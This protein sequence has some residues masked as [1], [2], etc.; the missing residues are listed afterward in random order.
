MKKIDLHIHTNST[1]SDYPFEFDFSKLKQYVETLDIACIAIT[2]HNTFDLK[3]Y[4]KIKDD[5]DIVVFPGIEIDLE[6]GHLLV[7]SDNSD[8]S[9][10]NDFSKKCDRVSQLIKTK[11]DDITVEQFADIFPSLDKFLLIPH[12]HK[13]PIVKTETIRKI[14]TLISAGEVSSYKKFK[15]CVK[16]PDSLVP[17]IFSDSR[18]FSEMENFSTQQTWVDL[19]EIS[20]AGIKLCLTDKQK[21]FLTK[22]EGN[23]FFQATAEGLMLSTGLNVILGERSTGKTVTLDKINQ[24]HENIKFIRQFSLL[25]NDEQKFEELLS[26]RHSTVSEDYLKDFKIVVDSV[27]N[28]DLKQNEIDLEKYLNSLLKFASDSE[29]ADAF[30]NTKLFSEN[31]FGKK[32]LSGLRQLI[33]AA[34]TIKENTEYK[35]LINRHITPATLED[36]EIDLMK[37]YLRLEEVNLKRE[38]VNNLITKIKDELIFRTSSPVPSDVDFYRILVEKEKIQKFTSITNNLKIEKEIDRK[39]IRGFK[40]VA[41]TKKFSSASHLKKVSNRQVSLVNAYSN[42]LQPYTFLM[43]LKKAEIED[44]ELFKYFVDIE[45]KTL[46]KLGFHVSGGERSEF[47]LL[48]EINDA[49]KHNMLLIDEPESSFDNIFLKNEVNELLRDISK[50]IPVIIVTHNSTVGASI[51]PNFIACTKRVIENGEIV[52]KTFSGFPSD[53]KLKSV[54][55]EEIDNYEVLLNCLEA[56][57]EEYERRRN[58]SYEILKN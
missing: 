37:E 53:K 55:G 27:K 34:K 58:E 6:G 15:S 57:N 21:V 45:Y 40:I 13:R 9:E 43:C 47:N 30:S 11:D 33:T 1:V 44:T 26:R 35:D 2:N 52:Y 56:G 4:L 46:N 48:H 19:D 28:I 25:Q 24:T 41:S 7:I 5:L 18:Y 29:K 39:E 36:L 22:E 38:W 31:H 51:K 10:I 17:V 16:D 54:D 32:D 49:L 14:N 23:E 20:L 12:Y 50:S 42:Y 3:Q 8:L